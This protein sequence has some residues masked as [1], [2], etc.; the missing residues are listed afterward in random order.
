MYNDR[1]HISRAIA[2]G[3]RQKRAFPYATAASNA[4]KAARIYL[5]AHCAEVGEIDVSANALAELQA[6]SPVVLKLW[7]QT[8]APTD[9]FFDDAGAKVAGS[10]TVS[11]IMETAR[12]MKRKYYTIEAV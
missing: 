8:R 9:D 4:L 3:A 5:R 12:D 6:G 2:H 10:V 7:V 11:L 1:Q